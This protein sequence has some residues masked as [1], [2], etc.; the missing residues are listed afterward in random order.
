MFGKMN[1]PKTSLFQ[2]QSFFIIRKK[3]VWVVGKKKETNMLSL[4]SNGENQRAK[5]IKF[6]FIRKT[7]RAMRVSEKENK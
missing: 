3:H 5:R 4:Y 2:I 6:K 7:K 1:L